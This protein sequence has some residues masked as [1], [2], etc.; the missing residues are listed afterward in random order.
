MTTVA[1]L[2]LS[3]N[4]FSSNPALSPGAIV[5]RTLQEENISIVSMLAVGESCTQGAKENDSRTTGIIAEGTIEPGRDKRNLSRGCRRLVLAQSAR[6]VA[7]AGLR[8]AQF[9][10]A[11][12]TASRIA[13]PSDGALREDPRDV[14]WFLFG[15]LQV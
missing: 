14:A 8:V 9:T 11:D 13:P 4:L 7:E 12:I 1:D 10:D 5:L 3:P 15:E 2:E 6:L